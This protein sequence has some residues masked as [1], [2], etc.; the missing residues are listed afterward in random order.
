MNS[1]KDRLHDKLE[2][3]RKAE[4]DLYFA[5][6]DKDALAKMKAQKAGPDPASKRCPRD[7]EELHE[8]KHL[9]VTI[10]QC[11][12]CEGIWLDK[13]ELQTIAQRESDSWLG[14]LFRP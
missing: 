13:G 3:K 5:E 2:Q 8:A 4:E 7:G 6:R 10:D 11:P 12:K 14:R 9:G 1:E